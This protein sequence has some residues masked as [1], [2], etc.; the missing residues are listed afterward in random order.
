MLPL[1][2]EEN[3]SRSRFA[4]EKITEELT[5]VEQQCKEVEDR[6]KQKTIQQFMKWENKSQGEMD[7]SIWK[8]WE[9]WNKKLEQVSK[10]IETYF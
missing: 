4:E 8:E 10:S 2:K 9:K 3:L 7:R 1:R 5:Q 6:V